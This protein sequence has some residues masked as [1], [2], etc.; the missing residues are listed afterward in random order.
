MIKIDTN[1]RDM[2]ESV[3]TNS[4]IDLHSESINSA[5]GNDTCISVKKCTGMSRVLFDRIAIER[6]TDKVNCRNLSIVRAMAYLRIPDIYDLSEI[7]G[8]EYVIASFH[9]IKGIV[10]EIVTLK[11]T[12]KTCKAIAVE[13]ILNLDSYDY[14]SEMKKNNASF[15]F[16]RGRHVSGELTFYNIGN[17]NE[18]KKLKSKILS[19][20]TNRE[21]AR[22]GKN[23]IPYNSRVKTIIKL[24]INKTLS[25]L[26]NSI[27]INYF[28]AYNPIIDIESITYLE[29]NGING[30]ISDTG[31]VINVDSSKYMYIY[32]INKHYILIPDKNEITKISNIERFNLSGEII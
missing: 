18:Y 29:N 11:S 20:N 3:S 26:D 5:F 19:I 6:V 27:F 32:A 30:G 15:W 24:D 25:S 14:I 22:F 21:I 7:E 17:W 13:F 12:D 1:V 8:Q 28:T 9:G 31:R 4:N 16:N 10:T 23:A 2:I